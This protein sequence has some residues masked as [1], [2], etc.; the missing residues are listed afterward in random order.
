[1]CSRHRDEEQEGDGFVSLVFCWSKTIVLDDAEMLFE[2]HRSCPKQGVELRCAAAM[3]LPASLLTC[4]RHEDGLALS[5]F[6]ISP[7]VCSVVFAGAFQFNSEPRAL[8]TIDD[9]HNIADVKYSVGAVRRAWRCLAE[10][11]I[12]QVTPQPLHF[13]QS[14]SDACG[15]WCFLRPNVQY[16]Q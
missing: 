7:S 3:S 11:P 8:T 4:S 16:L 9:A 2:V 15:G 6:P 5:A 14:P 10:R 1:M 13:S 12:C